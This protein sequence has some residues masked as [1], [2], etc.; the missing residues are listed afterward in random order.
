VTLPPDYVP[1]P[2]VKVCALDARAGYCVGCLR[3]ID[4]VAGW[5]EMTSEEKRAVL[6][7]IE[8]RRA[9]ARQ[10]PRP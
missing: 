9:A 3:T 7:R 1:S 2:C 10:E 4:E 5:L 6:D 8:L